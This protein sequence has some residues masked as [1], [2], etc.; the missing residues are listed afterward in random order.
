[1]EENQNQEQQQEQIETVDKAQY[2]AVLAELE[3]VK[4]KL[5]KEPTEE[6][7]ALQTKQVE[8]WQKEVSLSL[9]ENGLEQFASIV[10]VAD[11]NELKEVVK[12]LTQIVNDIKVSTG[13][14]PSDHKQITAYDQA[15][16][17]GDTKGMIKSLFGLN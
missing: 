11:E 16:Q 3:E 5:P 15:K 9:K 14:V 10:K 2:D 13:Y 12:T 7:K 8:L 1:M 17:K 4:G 6:E